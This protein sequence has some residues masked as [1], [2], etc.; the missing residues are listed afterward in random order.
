MILRSQ[1]T[2]A[3]LLV[4]P[5][6]WE[7]GRNHWASCVP[8]SFCPGWDMGL[9]L[10]QQCLLSPWPSPCS[11]GV[12]GNQFALESLAWWSQPLQFLRKT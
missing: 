9:R 11:L 6:A 2:S 4:W 7:R 10:F 3:L 1:W 5:G 8:L 12:S